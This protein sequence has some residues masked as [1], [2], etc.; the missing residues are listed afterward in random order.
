MI[1]V[2]DHLWHRIPPED[3]SPRLPEGHYAE[4]TRTDDNE[5]LARIVGPHAHVTGK[6]KNVWTAIANAVAWFEQ[7]GGEL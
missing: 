5:L 7:V 6:D 2:E 4:Y 3:M 1:P